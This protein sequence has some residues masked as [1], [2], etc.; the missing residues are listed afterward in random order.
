MNVTPAIST[1]NTVY[2]AERDIWWNPDELFFMLKTSV[3]PAR[4]GYFGRVLSEQPIDLP[5]S[6]L[7]DVGCGGGILAEA[8]AELGMPVTG[9]DP[10]VPSVETARGHAQ[11]RQLVIDYR[12]GSGE[13]LPF[14]D[15]HFDCVSCCDVLE[16]VQ[17]VDA[18]LAEIS[19]VLKPG[20]LFFYDT[21]NR[22]WLSWLFLIKIAQD[23]HRWA[24][25]EPNQH[26]YRRFIK[27]TEL[28]S[29]LARHGFAHQQTRGM[30]ADY[31]V[32]KT[33]SY[34]RK[35]R[36]G[37]WTFRE[38]GSRM[39]LREGRDTRLSYMGWARKN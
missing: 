37:A 23:W 3:N 34:L 31:N 20:G 12:V 33:L 6:T 1:N 39:T 11:Q 22:T 38:L 16:H 27:P 4:M 7:L 32:L 2:D 9:I 24:F 15:A 28:A 17:D 13:R 30:V 36:S 26:V 10:S 25:M 5:N 29:K 35:R 19:R 14:A 21:V 8:F 18:V